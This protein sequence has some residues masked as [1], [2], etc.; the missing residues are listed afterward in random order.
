[1]LFFYFLR[2][3]NT[4]SSKS[5]EMVKKAGKCIKLPQVG[6]NKTIRNCVNFDIKKDWF[7]LSSWKFLQACF[8]AFLLL[9]YTTFIFKKIDSHIHIL[10]FSKYIWIV[11]GN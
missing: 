5:L 11:V 9:D 8:L 10:T 7:Q 4:F 3:K 2:H 6:L 1:M